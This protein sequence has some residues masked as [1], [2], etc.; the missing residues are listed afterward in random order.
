MDGTARLRV[1]LLGGF[2]VTYGE[3]VVSLPGL[4]LRGLVVRLALAGGRPVPPDDLIEAIWGEQPPAGVAAA[5]HALGS[6]LRRA[7]TE[8]G[9]DPGVLTR[10]AGGYRLAVDPR[11]VDSLRFE[12]LAE[13][14]REELW[15]GGPG[16]ALAEAVGL[17]GGEPGSVPEAVAAVAPLVASRLARMSVEVVLDLAET[18]IAQ[19][20]A[21]SAVARL[22]RLVAEP[23]VHERAAGL[24]MDALAAT[25]RQAGALAVHERARQSLADDLGADPGSALR[26]RHRQLLRPGWQAAT[27]FVGRVGELARIGMLLTTGRLV[28]V[29][30]P[31]GA[32]KTR[33]AREAA[34]RHPEDVWFADLGA[35]AEG[36]ESKV[37]AAVLAGIGVHGGGRRPTLDLLAEELAGR[38][39]LLVADNCEH[40]VDAVAGLVVAL[41]Y[42]CPDLRVLATSRAPL[43]VD[44]ET[45]VPLGP[46]TLPV[47]GAG[48]DEARRTDAVVL[49]AARA[50]AVQPEIDLDLPTVIEVVRR[51]DGM[52]L[53]LELAAARLRTL[54]L[55]ELAAGL[56][57]RFGLL[58]EG[59]PAAPE[60]HRSLH[61]V[62]AWS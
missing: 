55:A 46:L 9:A 33:L 29:L 51:L 19:G 61:A 37:A 39:G 13:A 12:H 56:A 48:P 31:G 3:K 53:A 41:L 45:L 11:D 5:L 50:T 44:G 62:I 20:R 47:A 18:E 49:F 52:P 22:T 7:L 26:E 30:G 14:G 40:L 23:V 42:R 24:L 16:A 34:R 38:P 54:S 43:A 10:V 25:G 28:T 2:A 59:D 1:T 21:E 32:G 57:D 58:T 15:S 27:G 4:R 36:T 35:V 17:W 6:R 8:V 60:R